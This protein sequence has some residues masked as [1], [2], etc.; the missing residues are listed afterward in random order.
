MAEML[1]F[2]HELPAGGLP[3]CCVVCGA[4][5]CT[6]T[7]ERL[8]VIVADYEF[9]RKLRSSDG[10]LPLCE[11]HRLHFRRPLFAAL[12]GCGVM[13]LGIGLAI[14]VGLILGRIMGPG[15]EVSAFIALGLAAV[16]AVAGLIVGRQFGRRRMVHAINVTDEG[17]QL[18]N[19]SERF[20]AA[21][22][23]ARAADRGKK[24]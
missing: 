13:A 14:V 22:K 7:R 21:V 12:G 3:D 17:V 20:V 23:T 18:T 4:S 19:L 11:Q 15:N 16:S 1:L 24:P 5:S 10:W 8:A 6:P 2:A 9:V